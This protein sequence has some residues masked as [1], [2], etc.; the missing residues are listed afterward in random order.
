MPTLMY[1]WQGKALRIGGKAA[2]NSRCCCDSGGF[3]CCCPLFLRRPAP[4]LEAEI[5][6]PSCPEIDG[7][8]ITIETHSSNDDFCIWYASVATAPVGYCDDPVSLALY[9][10]C[11]LGGSSWADTRLSMVP[12]TSSCD[13]VASN[14]NVA[15][16]SGG[17]DPFEAQFDGF[18]LRR[19]PWVSGCDCCPGGFSIIVREKP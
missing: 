17:C 1:R 9:F 18:I 8:K 11:L 6:A 3:R 10:G 4:A 5:V 7:K 14:L 2:R 16:T 19:N 13:A 12:G 15:P